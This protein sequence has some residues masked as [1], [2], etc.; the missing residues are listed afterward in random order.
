MA[1]AA[2]AMRIRYLAV[3]P[4]VGKGGYIL[5]V[6]TADRATGFPTATPTP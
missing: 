3:R 5:G 4:V 2:I 6:L 1:L